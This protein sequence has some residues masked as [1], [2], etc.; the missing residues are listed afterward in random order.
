M[1]VLK[2]V[3][4]GNIMPGENN[5]VIVKTA[6]VIALQKFAL[7][8]LFN[9]QF[10]ILGEFVLSEMVKECMS[11]SNRLKQHPFVHRVSKHVQQRQRTGMM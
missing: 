2:M 8:D 3:E 4:S 9:K 7:W 1:A 10:L 11:M 5:F 6:L